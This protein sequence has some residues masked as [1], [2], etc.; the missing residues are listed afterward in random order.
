MLEAQ[1]QQRRRLDAIPDTEGAYGPYPE[2]LCLV[3]QLC[4]RVLIE[5]RDPCDR[6]DSYNL[7]GYE[8]PI[9]VYQYQG[10][11]LVQ[12]NP[13]TIAPPR[14][15]TPTYE[16]KLVDFPEG[17]EKCPL[18]E[19]ANFE[20]ATGQFTF[21]EADQDL[22]PPGTYTPEIKTCLGKDEDQICDTVEPPIIFEN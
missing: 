2:N 22:C 7:N 3:N 19:I 1:I 14:D 18:C 8:T 6:P 5:I 12:L 4:D 16:C 13:P 11:G 9:G 17:G 20:Y 10:T 21:E 15:C